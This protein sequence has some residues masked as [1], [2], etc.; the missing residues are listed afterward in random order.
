MIGCN[1]FLSVLQEL[2]SLK[3][4]ESSARDAIRWLELQLKAGSRFLRAQRDGQSRPL[5]L[6]KCPRKA[7]PH[8]QNFMQILEFC[9]HFIGDEKQN[10]DGSGD[11]ETSNGKSTPFL[12]L[13]LGNQS[14][15]DE[16]R[17]K[18]FSV[19]GA[20]KSVGISVEYIEDFYAKWRQIAHKS[21]KKR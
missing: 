4:E 17:Y 3:R 9:N 7:P 12:V 15:T 2:D 11:A 16:V 6:L 18:E 1:F 21:G 10:L 20:A 5:P 8:I 13:L 19:T 14:E